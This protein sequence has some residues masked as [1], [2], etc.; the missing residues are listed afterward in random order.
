MSDQR[1][2]DQK[3][4]D[5]VV[6]EVIRKHPEKKYLFGYLGSRFALGKNQFPHQM[7]F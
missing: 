3:A 1:K 6:L 2:E 5:S 4:V 7:L